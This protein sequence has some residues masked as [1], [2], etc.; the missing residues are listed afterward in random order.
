MNIRPG[1]CFL[2]ALSLGAIASS[3][4]VLETSPIREFD[5]AWENVDCA[6]ALQEKVFDIFEFCSRSV[7]AGK[8]PSQSTVP[9]SG[10]PSSR[11][12]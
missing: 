7:S 10:V 8:T 3:C 1:Y 9:R 11:F 6:I 12:A 2:V 4:S 5:Q